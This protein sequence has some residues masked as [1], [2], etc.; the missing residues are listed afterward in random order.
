MGILSGALRL[1][2]FHN[3]ASFSLLSLSAVI[4]QYFPRRILPVFALHTA[5]TKISAHDHGL[6][7]PI[8]YLR[9]EVLEDL[10]ALSR[11]QWLAHSRSSS[12]IA[13]SSSTNA[14]SFSSACTTKRFPSS[15][16]ASAIQIVRPLE[17]I[18]E[19][20]PKFQRALPRLSITPVHQV[21]RGKASN[22]ARG[23]KLWGCCHARLHLSDRLVD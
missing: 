3:C 7:L 18:A 1:Y 15:R 12:R 20:Q 5:M 22:L 16:C 19:T 23:A 8:R 9:D 13:D 2:E 21:R 4:S 11:N 17:S 14:V 10:P 6:R